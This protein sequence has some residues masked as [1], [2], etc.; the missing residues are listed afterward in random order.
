MDIKLYFLNSYG[1]MFLLISGVQNV[2]GPKENDVL[3]KRNN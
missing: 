3:W 1:G 2:S